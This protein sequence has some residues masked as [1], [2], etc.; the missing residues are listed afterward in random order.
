MS[1]RAV[2]K[3][4]PVVALPRFERAE[5]ALAH[6]TTA[7]AREKL[8][9]VIITTIPLGKQRSRNGM[10]SYYC[11]DVDSVDCVWIAENIKREGM[12]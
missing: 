12:E 4:A 8:R 10:R 1:K 3:V 7:L 6:L 2:R 9:A 5:D 11:G